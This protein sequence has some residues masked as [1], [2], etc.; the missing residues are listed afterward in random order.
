MQNYEDNEQLRINSKSFPAISRQAS[1]SARRFQSRYRRLVLVLAISAST[2]PVLTLI[3]HI[4]TRIAI[5]LVLTCVQLSTTL[6]NAGL[7]WNKK[8]YQARALAE[9]TKSLTW[10]LAVGGSPFPVEMPESETRVKMAQ[11]IIDLISSMGDTTF[12]NAALIPIEE[13]MSE[14]ENVRKKSLE[15]RQ[16]IYIRDR[17]QDQEKWYAM[18]AKDLSRKRQALNTLAAFSSL[19]AIILCL[20]LLVSPELFQFTYVSFFASLALGVIAIGQSHHLATDVSA[21]QLTHY[22]IKKILALPLPDNDRD[23]SEWVDDKEEALSREHVMWLA[24]RSQISR[25]KK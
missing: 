4:R 11:S 22:E 24:S 23:W 21:Y 20:L 10:R 18:K 5:A 9:S 7:G 8:W 14:I 17:M 25:M 19:I 12:L 1:E 16:Q 3:N 13:D 2:Y 6:I 15:V